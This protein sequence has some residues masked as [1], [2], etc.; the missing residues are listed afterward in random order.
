MAEPKISDDKALALQAVSRSLLRLAGAPEGRCRFWAE[1]F[2]RT[3]TRLPE[4]DLDWL[5]VLLAQLL[6]A[7]TSLGSDWPK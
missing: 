7:K 4:R 6:V 1:D 5:D 2:E 3:L